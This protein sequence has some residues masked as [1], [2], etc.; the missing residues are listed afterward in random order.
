MTALEIS[1]KNVP[2]K[3]TK[4]SPTSTSATPVSSSASEL[5]PAAIELAIAEKPVAPVAP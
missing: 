3:I 4:H 1:G 5:C 2:Q